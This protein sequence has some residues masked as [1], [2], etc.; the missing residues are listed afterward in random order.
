M[1]FWEKERM[2]KH[3]QRALFIRVRVNS[4]AHLLFT[5]P[6]CS[7]WYHISTI[8]LFFKNYL[9]PDACI[10]SSNL[11]SCWTTLVVHFVCF[12]E[13]KFPVPVF[14][15][16]ISVIRGIMPLSDSHCEAEGRCGEQCVL[17]RLHTPSTWSQARGSNCWQNL[18][19]TGRANQ[20]PAACSLLNGRCVTT[21]DLRW[22][23]F[24]LV[25]KR[26]SQTCATVMNSVD[27]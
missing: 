13:R 20:L 14:G 22:N 17:W 9:Q 16:N 8:M 1:T 10:N 5:S 19:G 21:R 25:M 26:C 18:T 15:V 11:F 4:H 3:Q 7:F 6:Y 24:R 12:I 23:R 27:L 2:L